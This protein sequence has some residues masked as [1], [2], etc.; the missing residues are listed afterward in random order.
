[1]LT[2]L[3]VWILAGL[4]FAAAV[5]VWAD[6]PVVINLEVVLGPDV[7][8]TAPQEWAQRLGQLGLSRLQI[9]SV[10][11]PEKPR[12]VFNQQR[13]RIDVLAVLTSRNELVLPERRFRASDIV[14]LREYFGQL[15]QA[16]AEEGV[17]RGLF[18]LTEQQF[19]ELLAD[20]GRPVGLPT[21]GRTSAE[22]LTH[23]DRQFRIP[24]RRDVQTLPLLKSGQPLAVELQDLTGGTLLA[25]ALRRDGLTFV[26]LVG[27][28]GKLELAVSP[29]QR[30]QD[31]WPPGWRP[32]GSPRQAAPRLYESLSVEI[33]GF[34]LASALKALSPR[35][36][37]PV[38]MDEWTLGQLDIRPD[39]IKVKLPRKKTTLKS[40]VDRLCSQARLAAEVRVDERDTPFLWITQFGPDSERSR[41]E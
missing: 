21:V 34:T 15:P 6:V 14:A 37:V 32:Q 38:V 26:P 12:A 4:L 27:A 11:S 18:N 39:T 16:L 28:S 36:G 19:G 30:G 1:M 25:I 2:C 13:T 8:I 41:G 35:L 17:E 29:Y 33:E 3:R 22:I 20:L 40:T 5:P 24:I 7:P 23:C 31:T 10:R 9:H